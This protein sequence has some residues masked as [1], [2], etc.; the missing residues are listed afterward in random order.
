MA[1]IAQQ[2]RQQIGQYLFSPSQQ[3]AEETSV[4][5]P[6]IKNESSPVALAHNK[7][8]DDPTESKLI[9]GG[10]ASIEFDPVKIGNPPAEPAAIKINDAP[11]EPPAIKNDNG[12]IEAAAFAGGDAPTEPVAIEIRDTSAES[13]VMKNDNAPTVTPAKETPKEV[14]RGTDDDDTIEGYSVTFVENFAATMIQK[15]VRGSKM[16]TELPALSRQKNPEQEEK[17]EEGKPP[18]FHTLD[19][20]DLRSKEGKALLE[21]KGILDMHERRCDRCKRFREEDMPAS[22][23]FTFYRNRCCC[24][25]ARLATTYQMQ[26]ENSAEERN[27]GVNRLRTRKEQT[28]YLRNRLLPPATDP[29]KTYKPPPKQSFA[30]PLTKAL[31]ENDIKRASENWARDS[32]SLPGLSTKIKKNKK[33]SAKAQRRHVEELATPPIWPTKKLPE[34]SPFGFGGNSPRDIQV[35]VGFRKPLRNSGP[36]AIYLRRRK[37]RSPGL[38]AEQVA[39]LDDPK[40]SEDEGAEEDEFTRQLRQHAERRRRKMAARNKDEKASPARGSPKPNAPLALAIKHKR[41]HHKRKKKQRAQ[42]LKTAEDFFDDRASRMPGKMVKSAYRREHLPTRHKRQ[43]KELQELSRQ[44]SEKPSMLFRVLA[45][46]H[47]R[48]KMKQ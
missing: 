24:C 8:D 30:M 33:I 3:T 2:W 43:G 40:G 36:A 22:E 20:D 32:P 9:D 28:D 1:T 12:P 13:M 6:V 19:Y 25:G 5:S 16:R 26:R 44:R 14:I 31:N 11:S 10:N 38:T 17:E 42:H 29:P 45:D 41:R 23:V 7:D 48:R 46:A 47:C 39:T 34:H 37:A 18:R 27:R 15:V 4:E 35:L 21:V